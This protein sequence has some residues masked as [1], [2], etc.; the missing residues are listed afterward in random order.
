MKEEISE[1]ES[2]KENDINIATTYIF[3][4]GEELEAKVYF[5]NGFGSKVNFEYLPLLIVNSQGEEIGSQVFDLREM[6]D[7]PSCSARPW[8]LFFNKSNVD[9]N[10]FSQKDCKVIFN[11]NIKAVNYAKIEYEDFPEAYTEFRQAFEKFLSELPN[12]EN[13]MF[14]IATFSISIKDNSIF[15][16]LVARNGSNQPLKV[17]ELPITIKDENNELVLSIKV[18]LEDFIVSPMKAKICN[19]AIE[20]DVNFNENLDITKWIVIF[21]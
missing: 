11:S 8:K 4:D 2:I 15:V 6:G 10:K 17:E 20:N 1:F 5:R 14:N 3:D 18:K 16:T 7:I 12:I 13:G 9:M 21:E 19:I